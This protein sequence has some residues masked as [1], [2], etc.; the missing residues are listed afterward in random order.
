MC[1][2]SVLW[3]RHI[4][5]GLHFLLISA[6]FEHRLPVRKYRDFCPVQMRTAGGRHPHRTVRDHQGKK[7]KCCSRAQHLLCNCHPLLDH[8]F[9]TMKA[10]SETVSGSFLGQLVSKRPP[11]SR[12][13]PL[14]PDPKSLRHPG[15][16]ALQG[17]PG[18]RLSF[19][20][21]LQ[22]RLRACAAG[23]R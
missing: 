16:P 13:H 2:F 22:L 17:F 21:L 6:D 9:H 8:I 20:S 12:R 1:S 14:R 23:R 15:F 11:I 4:S 7:K 18:S 19:E 5:T 3:G 10:V